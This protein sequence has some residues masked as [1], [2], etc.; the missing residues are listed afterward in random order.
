MLKI[1]GLLGIVAACGMAGILKTKD[2]KRRVILLED[3]LR[4][5]IEIK[6]QINYFRD[7]LPDIFDKLRKN[8]DSK[9]FSLLNGLRDEIGE[10]G[11]DMVK[12]WPLKIEETYKNEPLK[13]DDMDIFRYP[14]EFMGQTDYDNHIY[15]F[16]YVEDK[17]QKQIENAREELR[18][19]GPMYGRIGF[20]LGA[21]IAI[22]FI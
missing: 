15:H 6:G 12:I 9:A 20:F 8:G 22:I 18:Q 16:S 7:P 4:M 17:L 14:G 21:M 11:G 13:E 10:K 2:L 3:Y 19:K 1:L 5:I